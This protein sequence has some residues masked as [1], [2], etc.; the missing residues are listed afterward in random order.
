MTEK[1]KIP[2]EQLILTDSCKTELHPTLAN[3]FIKWFSP[4]NGLKSVSYTH[5]RA[6]ETG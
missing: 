4:M 5:L 2:I 6:H 1:L 3:E